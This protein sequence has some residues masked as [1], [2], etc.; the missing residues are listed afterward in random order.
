[1]LPT[2]CAC[3][4]LTA[5]PPPPPSPTRLAVQPTTHSSTTE[6]P[7]TPRDQIS[8]AARR[9]IWSATRV[10]HVLACRLL[11]VSRNGLSNV[12]GSVLWATA[13]VV[14]ASDNF[15][16]VVGGEVPALLPLA[17]RRARSV[18]VDVADNW[19]GSGSAGDDALAALAPTQR[20]G[21]VFNLSANCYTGT[22]FAVGLGVCSGQGLT[23]VVQQQRGCIQRVHAPNAPV[24]VTA[25]AG[26][27]ST[28]V[29][30]LPPRK[31]YPM[32]ASYTVTADAGSADVGAITTG[33]GVVGVRPMLQRYVTV[34]YTTTEAVVTGLT[35]G[36]EYAVSVVADNGV[37][38]AVSA[39]VTVTPCAASGTTPPLP[40]VSAV[41]VSGV[42]NISVSWVPAALSPCWNGSVQLWNVSAACATSNG[43]VVWGT[44]LLLGGAV[45]TAR[46]SGVPRLASCDYSVGVSGRNGAGWSAT[47]MVP[48]DAPID[49]PGAPEAVVAVASNNRSVLVQ[50]RP[51]DDD[52]GAAVVGY[53]VV[54]VPIDDGA[55]NVT[56]S[57]AQ[58]FAAVG[59]LIAG[60]SYAVA[61]AARNVAGMGAA[62]VSGTSYVNVTTPVSVG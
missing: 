35:P 40:P 41:A 25:Q 18:V 55:P 51:P 57:T 46:A 44:S 42:R 37:T 26:V 14:N 49:V 5:L 52:G 47:T 12:S 31:S 54:V 24:A 8:H 38:T 19:F 4:V 29:R 11:D 48:A 60:T 61:V 58:P 9:C 56:V 27:G 7:L 22:G 43:T 34:P 13:S 33:V 17:D 21:W 59:G 36:V 15:L 10:C 28:A 62:A 3:V 50:W 16:G 45:T 6:P 39:S 20:P 53:T 2:N 1:M 23:C 30:W 32:P